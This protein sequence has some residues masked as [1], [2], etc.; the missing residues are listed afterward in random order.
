MLYGVRIVFVGMYFTLSGCTLGMINSEFIELPIE[1]KP[2]GA[3]VKIDGKEYVTPVVAN[4]RRRQDG[5]NII[6]E[7]EGYKTEYVQL[8]SKRSLMASPIDLLTNA[9]EMY[10]FTPD[11]INLQLTAATTPQYT[12]YSLDKS[13]VTSLYIASYMSNN[14]IWYPFSAD[15]MLSTIQDRAISELSKPGYFRITTNKQNRDSKYYVGIL[16]EVALIQKIDLAKLKVIVNYPNGKN[17]IF[18]ES[19]TLSGKDLQ[20]I[21]QTLEEL[22]AAAAKRFL[23]LVDE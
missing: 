22:G 8:A 23:Q 11:K 18:T 2:S 10:Y 7:K 16:L 9:Q 21:Y 14:N 19:K 13:V 5:L 1:T 3:T 4:V 15:E 17:Y 6:V 12:K 20:G